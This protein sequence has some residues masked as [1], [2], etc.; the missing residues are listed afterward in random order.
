MSQLAPLLEGATLARVQISDPRWSAPLPPDALAAALEGRR[1][2]RLGRRGKYI[3]WELDDGRR[4]VQ[5]LRMTGVLLYDPTPDPTHVRVRMALAGGPN[6]ALSAGSAAHTLVI[7]D[8]RRF[9]TAT[10]CDDG[11]ALERFFA[12]R[13]G[14]EPF[15]EAFSGAYLRAALRHSRRA[16]KAALLDQ[17]LVAGV[18]NI[19]ADEA[20]FAAGVH[21]ARRADRLSLAQCERLHAGVVAAIRAGI[22]ARG[23]SIDDFRHVDGVRGSFQ[24]RF[25]VHRRAGEPCPR[26]ATEIVKTV[27]AGRGTYCCPRCQPPPRRVRR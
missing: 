10:L 18:G 1:V 19:Y 26:C 3:V 11:R 16:I 6:S 21:P 15:D 13:L 4:L 12:E 9:G 2:E 27:V 23:A 14:P 22:D 7:C 5:H 25:M 8:P 17:R 24:D 20:L